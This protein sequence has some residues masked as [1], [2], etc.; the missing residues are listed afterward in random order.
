MS[1]FGETEQDYVAKLRWVCIQLYNCEVLKNLDNL[2][3]K[4]NSEWSKFTSETPTE[5]KFEP[6]NLSHQKS[7]SGGECEWKPKIEI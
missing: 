1:R 2:K 3:T 4:S 7:L 5:S 6:Y